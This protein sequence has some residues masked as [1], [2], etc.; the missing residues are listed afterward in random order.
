MIGQR[1]TNDQSLAVYYVDVF[2]VGRKN[3]REFM[4]TSHKGSDPQEDGGKTIG[5]QDHLYKQK[6][7][8]GTEPEHSIGVKAGY[9]TTGHYPS[10]SSTV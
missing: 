3:V 2:K 9:P 10:G 8:P 4:G 5:E 1:P 6:S 7:L